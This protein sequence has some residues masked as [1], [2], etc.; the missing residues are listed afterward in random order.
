MSLSRLMDRDH[1][2]RESQTR[3]GVI[4]TDVTASP[5]GTAVFEQVSSLLRTEL[6]G[7]VRRSF[8]VVVV[9]V[10]GDST[11][12]GVDIFAPAGSEPVA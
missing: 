8:L 5:P 1:P 3:F 10:D 9:K 7:T 4:P 6:D 11:L 12:Q 2:F